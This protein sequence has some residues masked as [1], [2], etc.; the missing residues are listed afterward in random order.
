VQGDTLLHFLEAMKAE[1]GDCVGKRGL[2]LL[3]T[4]Q[5]GGC[6]KHWIF[7]LQEVCMCTDSPEP[8]PLALN[9]LSADALGSRIHAWRQRIQC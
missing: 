1:D 6:L 8:W 7:A 2:E 9:A 3:L 4:P 5:L